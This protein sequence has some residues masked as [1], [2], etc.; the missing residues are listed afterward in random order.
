MTALSACAILAGS[1]NGLAAPAKLTLDQLRQQRKEMAAKK[2]RIIMN[3]DGCEAIYFPKNEKL[4]VESFLAKRTTP[5][6]GS[7]VDTIAFCLPAPASASSR[8]TQR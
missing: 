2:R 7:E 4:T 1:L 8:T 5:L 6:A 3:N